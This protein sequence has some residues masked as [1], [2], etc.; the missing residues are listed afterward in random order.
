MRLSRTTKFKV[1]YVVATAICVLAFT[2]ILNS[3]NWSAWAFF[4][5]IFCLILPGR[6]QGILLRD[7]FRGRK[8]LTKGRPSE[9]AIAFNA[10]LD[11]LARD[12]RL[13]WTI[14]LT[15]PI[16]TS[17]LHAMVLNDLG[18]AQHRLKN[19]AGA[20]EAW[21]KALEIDPGYAIPYLNLAE[22]AIMAGRFKSAGAYLDRARKCGYTDSAMDRL[23]HRSQSM[24]VNI[25]G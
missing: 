3:I 1:G 8:E 7:L 10:M 22:K 20:A 13:A 15:W 5:G 12:R 6:V 2:A 11:R 19:Y 14:W 25:E 9:A 21:K 23:I 16:Y 18:V 4:F 17:S 24:L